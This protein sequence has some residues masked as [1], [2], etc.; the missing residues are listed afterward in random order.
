MGLAAGSHSRERENH[1]EAVKVLL[2]GFSRGK[3][4]VYLAEMK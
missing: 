3:P 2:L 4:A 1:R